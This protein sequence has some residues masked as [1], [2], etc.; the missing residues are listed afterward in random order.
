MNVF[1]KIEYL[2]F[3]SITLLNFI[4]L[5]KLIN[6]RE[7]VSLNIFLMP[8]PHKIHKESNNLRWII[9]MCR[10]RWKRHYLT[11]KHSRMLWKEVSSPLKDPPFQLSEDH[12]C[13]V[14]HWT[15]E[16]QKRFK[17][18]NLEQHSNIT[19]MVCK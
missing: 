19:W 12:L 18:H 10:L 3:R 5:D 14:I 15:W 16:K 13:H 2:Q 4:K 1:Y 7:N 11:F 9:V 8:R 6:C 17:L